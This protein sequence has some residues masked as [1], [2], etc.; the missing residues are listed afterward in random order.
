MIK[1]EI[2]K[3]VLFHSFAQF[4]LRLMASLH[5]LY[6]ASRI[7]AFIE[8]ENDDLED[9]SSIVSKDQR[10]TVLAAAIAAPNEVVSVM[11]GLTTSIPSMYL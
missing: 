11:F 4:K 7:S 10:P 3:I 6:F 5:L 8:A 9:V 2:Q 1:K